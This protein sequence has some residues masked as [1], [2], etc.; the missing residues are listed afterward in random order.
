MLTIELT[1]RFKNLLPDTLTD[2]L[3]TLIIGV[4]V[5]LI[6]QYH[7]NRRKLYNLAS[8]IHAPAGYPYYPIVGHSYIFAGSTESIFQ[9]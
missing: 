8:K 2:F 9:I 1:D 3:I 5:T 4:T 7:W 6:V